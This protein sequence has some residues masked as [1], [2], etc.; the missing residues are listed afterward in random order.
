MDMDDETEIIATYGIRQYQDGEE[1]DSL[2]FTL[3]KKIYSF[4]KPITN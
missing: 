1:A 2:I 3:N 4:I